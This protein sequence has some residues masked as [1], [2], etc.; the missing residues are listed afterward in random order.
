MLK[1]F[2]ELTDELSEYERCVLVPLFVSGFSKKRGKENAITNKQIVSTLAPKGY[3]V[4]DV[5]V[6]KIVNHIRKNNLVEGLIA[7]SAGYYISTDP[8]E[9]ADYI[10]SLA[11]RENEIRRIRKQFEKYLNQIR[12]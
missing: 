11:G 3:K 2:E 6:R 5:R 1:G 8:A 4:S 9:V 7:T 10:E 12:I